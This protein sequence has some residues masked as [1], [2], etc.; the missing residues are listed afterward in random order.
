MIPGILVFDPKKL[1][2]ASALSHSSR[3][4]RSPL[5]SRNRWCRAPS[6]FASSV[7]SSSRAA[8]AASACKVRGHAIPDRQKDVE[9]LIAFLKK[10]FDAEE[11]MRSSNPEGDIRHAEVRIGDSA[12]SVGARR[13]SPSSG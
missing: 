3:I 10:T 1:W 2:K 6:P 13:A 7:I 12:D 5:L 11:V 8:F 9:G 4:T